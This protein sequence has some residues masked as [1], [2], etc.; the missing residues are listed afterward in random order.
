M[1]EGEGTNKD[2]G[3][4]SNRWHGQIVDDSVWRDNILAGKY[5]DKDSVPGWGRRYK[6][7]VF[8]EHDLGGEDGYPIPDEQLPWASIEFPVTAGSGAGNCKQTPALRQGNIVSGYWADG[9]GKQMPV[10]TGVIGNNEQILM[11]TEFPVPVTESGTS[12]AVSAFPNKQKKLPDLVCRPKPPQDALITK[13]PTPAGFTPPPKPIPTAAL[14]D[15]G[16][17]VNLPRTPEILA[18]IRRATELADARAGVGQGFNVEQ[19]KELTKFYV[20]R[21]LKERRKQAGSPFSITSPGATTEALGEHLKTAQDIGREHK[22]EEKIVLM[23]PDDVVESATKAI[24]TI[25]DNLSKQIELYTNSL[26]DYAA[27][28]QRPSS[29]FKKMVKDSACQ[30]SKYMK[31][32]M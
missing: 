16:L 8:G 23:T 3:S 29:D 1:S 6:V 21:G 5:E 9:Y 20:Q 28:T 22:C 4:G 25:N 15:F 2:W 17:Q 12:L 32:I 18:D 26:T 7:R 13:K 24:Q 11:G 30:I 31:V 14:D 19:V 10:I 27:A